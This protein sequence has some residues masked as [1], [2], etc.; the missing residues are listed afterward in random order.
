[1][2]ETNEKKE[3]ELKDFRFIRFP[4]LNKMQDN[5][6]EICMDLTEEEMND[7]EVVVGVLFKK[8]VLSSEQLKNEV[9]LKR[10]LLYKGTPKAM[11][12][13]QRQSTVPMNGWK[14]GEGM[15]IF[16]KV[17]EYNGK[18]TFCNFNMTQDNNLLCYSCIKNFNEAKKIQME[19]L[20][21]D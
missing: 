14:S 12:L 21:N 6:T 19:E 13:T 7:C 5:F 8:E 10:V 20:K 3:P 1:M 2:N 4:S 15:Q 18:C 11:F 16:S 17:L 9:S